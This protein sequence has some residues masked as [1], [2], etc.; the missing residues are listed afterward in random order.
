MSVDS[1]GRTA[2]RFHQEAA[3]STL[4]WVNQ[5][6]EIVVMAAEAIGKFKK[7]VQERVSSGK[8]LCCEKPALKRGLC[9][10][11]YYKWRTVRVT[12]GSA[13]KQASFDAKLI[14]IGK[15]LHPQAVRDIK[16]RNIFAEVAGRE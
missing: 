15:L 13:S 6:R 12:L 1:T 9:Y 3:S 2:R 11:C 7:K 16:S 5:M 4:C 14:R 8:C 10:Q